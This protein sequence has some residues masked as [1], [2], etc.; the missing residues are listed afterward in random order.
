MKFKIRVA[1]KASTFVQ[2]L[3]AINTK[4]AELKDLF[5]CFGWEF[6]TS[7]GETFFTASY[8]DGNETEKFEFPISSVSVDERYLYIMDTLNELHWS[9]LFWEKEERK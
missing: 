6:F 3:H 7:H 9:A 4:C 1:T 2:K 5:P 8:R